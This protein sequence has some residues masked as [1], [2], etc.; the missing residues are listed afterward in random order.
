VTL[1]VVHWLYHLS[2][3]I[4]LALL[5]LKSVQKHTSVFQNLFDSLQVTYSCWHLTLFAKKYKFLLSNWTRT[6]LLIYLWSLNHSI[7]N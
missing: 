1:A 2:P 3:W 7:Q 4:S 5:K 6:R